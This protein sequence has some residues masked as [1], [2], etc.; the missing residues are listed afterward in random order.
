MF[1]FRSL[2]S[3]SQVF[4]ALIISQTNILAL[5]EHSYSSWLSKKQHCNSKVHTEI[6][7]DAGDLKK[8][9]ELPLLK[10][11]L[12]STAGFKVHWWCI[13]EEGRVQQRASTA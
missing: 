3:I 9:Y 6:I 8:Q 13:F 2:D 4:G 10:E 1:P 12:I 11:L 7:K 5:H